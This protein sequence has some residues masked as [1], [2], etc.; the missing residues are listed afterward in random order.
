MRRTIA[1]IVVAALAMFVVGLAAQ[2]KSADPPALTDLERA[3]VDV[4]NLKSQLVELLKRNA[5]VQSAYGQCQA[6]LGPLQ[7]KDNASAVAAEAGALKSAIEGAHPGFTFDAATGQLVPAA[8]AA[9]PPPPVAGRGG[10]G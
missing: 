6:L 7:Q 2:Q 8:K 1:V 5:D 3:R 4:I 9:S 10:G